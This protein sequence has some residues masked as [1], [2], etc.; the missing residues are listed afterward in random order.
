[1]SVLK[2]RHGYRYGWVGAFFYLSRQN[3]DKSFMKTQM[4]PG[5]DITVICVSFLL[6]T[7]LSQ[8]CYCNNTK[9]AYI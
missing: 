2:E 6:S 5:K 7:Y 3:R 9:I 1:V 8:E 4:K